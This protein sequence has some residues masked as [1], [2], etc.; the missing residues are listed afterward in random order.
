MGFS[1]VS[2]DINVGIGLVLAGDNLQAAIAND[3]HYT[4]STPLQGF[5]S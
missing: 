4:G 3:H 5:A 1:K 2:W